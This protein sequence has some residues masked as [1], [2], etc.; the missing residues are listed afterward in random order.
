MKYLL[1]RKRRFLL[2]RAAGM[3]VV[4]VAVPFQ[5]Q[6]Q[7]ERILSLCGRICSTCISAGVHPETH[8]KL[9]RKIQRDCI[10]QMD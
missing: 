2:P 8:R 3:P 1:S 9:N 5:F 7:R 4:G 10:L 6:S